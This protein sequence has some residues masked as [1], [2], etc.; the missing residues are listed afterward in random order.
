MISWLFKLIAIGLLVVTS[1]PAFAVDKVIDGSAG[2]DTLNINYSGISSLKDFTL[3]TYASGELSYIKATDASGNIIDFTR[4]ESLTVNSISY[5]FAPST[6]INSGDGGL[7]NAF[8]STSQK[9]FI[10]MVL[11]FGMHKTF[12]QDHIL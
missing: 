8:Y 7:S 1:S 4:I 12:V 6:T 5:A 9:L 3:S 10:V 11:L 2:T